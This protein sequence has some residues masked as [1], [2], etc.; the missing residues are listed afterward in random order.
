MQFIQTPLEPALG[1]ALVL[2]TYFIQTSQYTHLI[3]PMIK[4]AYQEKAAIGGTS[5]DSDLCSR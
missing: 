1:R 2:A 4:N 3:Y 5:E